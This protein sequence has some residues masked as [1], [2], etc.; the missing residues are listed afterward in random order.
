MRKTQNLLLT[1]AVLAMVLGFNVSE[2]LA[3][4]GFAR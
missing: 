1:M 2:S 3:G 4:P